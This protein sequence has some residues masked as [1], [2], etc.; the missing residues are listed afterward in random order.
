MQHSPCFEFANIITSLAGYSGFLATMLRFRRA[1]GDFPTFK[2]WLSLPELSYREGSSQWG[3]RDNMLR[4]LNRRTLHPKAAPSSTLHLNPAPS[5]L[6]LS[7]GCRFLEMPPQARE[8]PPQPPKPTVDNYLY[9]ST[10]L[11]PK[12]VPTYERG[13][14]SMLRGCSF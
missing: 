12:Q 8:S 14:P 4:I 11:G 5:N 10:V 9:N 7:V 6:M 3:V 2:G 13:G 1:G